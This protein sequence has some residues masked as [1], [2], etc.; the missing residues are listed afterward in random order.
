MLS[1]PTIVEIEA[2]CELPAMLSG[3]AE[4]TRSELKRRI[5]IEQHPQEAAYCAESEEAGRYVQAADGT[6]IVKEVKAVAH[7][8]VQRGA[9]CAH[10]FSQSN[11]L[12]NNLSPSLTFPLLAAAQDRAPRNIEAGFAVPSHAPLRRLLLR[13]DHAHSTSV[14]CDVATRTVEG[15][16]FL[17]LLKPSMNVIHACRPLGQSSFGGCK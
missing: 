11:Y 12:V 4:E 3:L 2:V 15:G 5:A 1:A 7:L 13:Y 9:S 17:L 14:Q 10:L 6:R 8:A 16:S